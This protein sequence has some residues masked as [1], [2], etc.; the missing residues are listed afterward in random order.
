MPARAL[1]ALV[2]ALSVPALALA[3]TGSA[4]AAP[5]STACSSTK[6]TSFTTSSTSISVGTKKTKSVD[7]WVTVSDACPSTDVTVTLTSPGKS[8]TFTADKVDRLHGSG[9]NGSVA[10][11]TYYT[12]GID[13]EPKR[14]QASDA[15]TWHSSAELRTEDATTSTKGPDFT[16]RHATRTTFNASPEPLRKGKPLNLLGRL[17]QADWSTQKYVPKPHDELVVQWRPKSGGPFQD[18][19]REAVDDGA[20]WGSTLTLSRS[21]CFRGVYAGDETLAPTTSRTDCVT[22][23]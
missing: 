15:G 18:F 6:I 12:V 2:L 1:P 10:D 22:V 11:V 7:L 20:Y 3:P 5:R 13:L 9:L 17:S 16:V 19:S 23:K 14:L 8:R 4:D 21:A